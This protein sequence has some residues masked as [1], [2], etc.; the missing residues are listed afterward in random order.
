MASRKLRWKFMSNILNSRKKKKLNKNSI[1]VKKSIC[2]AWEII[3]ESGAWSV[4]VLA[5]N[6]CIKIAINQMICIKY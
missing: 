1:R 4:V 6:K 3:N 5:N 2:Y